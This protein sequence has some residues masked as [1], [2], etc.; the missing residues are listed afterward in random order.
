MKLINMQ[1]VS[2]FTTHKTEYVTPTDHI[3]TKIHKIIKGIF[4]TVHTVAK[5]DPYNITISRYM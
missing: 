4:C 2:T 5:T 3:E 1:H